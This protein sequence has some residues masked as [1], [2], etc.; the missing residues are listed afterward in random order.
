MGSFSLTFLCEQVKMF[1][2]IALALAIARS[3]AWDPDNAWDQPEDEY[4]PWKF[5]FPNECNMGKWPVT[6]WDMGVDGIEEWYSSRDEAMA[7]CEEHSGCDTA[8]C[9]EKNVLDHDH[10]ERLK[11][12]DL[13]ERYE[14]EVIY[15]NHEERVSFLTVV[16]IICGNVD[17]ECAYAAAGIATVSE[18]LNDYNLPDDYF[19]VSKSWGRVFYKV[20]SE[21]YDYDSAKTQCQS[22]GAFLAIPR[23]EAE[24]NFIA[25]L[26]PNENILIGINDIDQEGVFVAVDGS[27][28]TYTNWGSGEPNNWGGDEDAVI[29]SPYGWSKTWNDQ[30]A[31]HQ[32]RFVCSLRIQESENLEQA[33]EYCHQTCHS[34]EMDRGIDDFVDPCSY[35]LWEVM[36][37]DDHWDHWD[38]D[39]HWNDDDHHDDHNDNPYDLWNILMSSSVGGCQE[40][41]WYLSNYKNGI[42]AGMEGVSES[43]MVEHC[44]DQCHGHNSCNRLKPEDFLNHDACQRIMHGDLKELYEYQVI[45]A[46]DFGEEGEQRAY[47]MS[48]MNVMCGNMEIE[49]AYA[50]F[51]LW[52]SVQQGRNIFEKLAEAVETPEMA[53]CREKCKGQMWD[54]AF[55]DMVNPCG[56][57]FNSLSITILF[58]I[59]L[60]R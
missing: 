11:Y 15:D 56:S 38:D 4:T 14:N 43:E 59:S 6:N 52:D 37:G 42:T 30:A 47:M 40:A 26:I 60:V 54:K 5:I 12:G 58:I 1:R 33:E 18:E 3:S 41:K 16:N 19:F 34:G 51:D 46:L 25:D 23:S 45:D 24:N 36:E 9:D 21:H 35:E 53:K 44:E 57:L 7:Y 27:N 55:G 20:Y 39:D 48:L 29:I 17:V 2:Q 13:R 22:D 10:C 49:C 32:A 28:I 50:A 31:Y 8:A